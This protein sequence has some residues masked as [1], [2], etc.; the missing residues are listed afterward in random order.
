LSFIP[1]L[2]SLTCPPPPSMAA[3]CGPFFFKGG[4]FLLDRKSFPNFG[5]FSLLLLTRLSPFPHS[6]AGAIFFPPC[7]GVSAFRSLVLVFPPFWA[8]P[9][10]E[11]PRSSSLSELGRVLSPLLAFNL[12]FWIFTPSLF[13]S[14][15]Q[16]LGCS[17]N[18]LAWSTSFWY[19]F[20]FI[21]APGAS[22]PPWCG[23]PVYFFACWV[24]P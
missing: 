10:L 4:F 20:C 24:Y 15:P 11:A 21:F 8:D 19:P 7:P 18:P 5:I 22:F 3:A 9:P 23:R 1:P 6:L 2:G 16:H 12:G 13:P 17:H 14:L